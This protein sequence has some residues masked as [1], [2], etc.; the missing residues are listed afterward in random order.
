MYSLFG[1][2]GTRMTWKWMN[3]M[4]DVGKMK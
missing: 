2:V 1:Q 3:E 4:D